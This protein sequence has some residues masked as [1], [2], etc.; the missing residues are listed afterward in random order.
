MI[1]KNPLL[2]PELSELLKAGGMGLLSIRERLAWLPLGT[3]N[4]MVDPLDPLLRSNEM[5]STRLRMIVS[6]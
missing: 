4:R 5:L 1:T 3:I 2:V 6:C